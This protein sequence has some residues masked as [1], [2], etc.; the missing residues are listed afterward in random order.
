MLIIIPHC[1]RVLHGSCPQKQCHY[2]RRSSYLMRRNDGSIA[3][4]HLSIFLILHKISYTPIRTMKKFSIK[5]INPISSIKI[6]YLF[7]SKINY[8]FS[9][10]SSITG[11][12]EVSFPAPGLLLILEPFACNGECPAA[13][14]HLHVDKCVLKLGSSQVM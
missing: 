12:V 6:T 14:G 9:L 3:C 10:Y 8:L 11:S 7:V 2:Q 4:I 5:R 1:H 13:P